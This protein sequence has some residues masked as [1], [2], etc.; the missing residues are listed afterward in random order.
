MA[1]HMLDWLRLAARRGTRVLVGDPGR[2]YLP[3]GLER[4]A[5]YRVRTSREIEDAEIKESAVFTV[6]VG[7]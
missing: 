7:V 5:T 4:L 2:T 6:P 1:G 3:P